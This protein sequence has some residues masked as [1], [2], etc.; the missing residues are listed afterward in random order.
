MALPG[1]SNFAGTVHIGADA[2]GIE[3]HV[4]VRFAG[5]SMLEAEREQGPLQLASSRVNGGLDRRE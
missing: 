3:R 1:A 2:R 4:V 5:G